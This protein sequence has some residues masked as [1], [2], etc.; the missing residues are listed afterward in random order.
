M[1]NN[2]FVIVN[3]Y[4]ENIVVEAGKLI[5]RRN[6]RV[7]NLISWIYIALSIIFGIYEKVKNNSMII[8]IFGSGYTV[9][10]LYMLNGFEKNK[11]NNNNDFIANLSDKFTFYDSYYLYENSM[12]NNSCGKVNY[13]EIKE[14]YISEN[15]FVLK[16]SSM[17]E[18]SIICKDSFDVGGVDEFTDF[19]KCKFKGKLIYI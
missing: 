10:Y 15:I 1:N 17:K 4:N 12:N 11:I 14:V 8:L 3:K 9:I 7:I 6:F 5:N 19:L 16:G 13:E 18:I 2:K